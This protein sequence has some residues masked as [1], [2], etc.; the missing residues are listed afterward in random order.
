MD[1]SLQKIELK[2]FKFFK[3]PFTFPV[4]GKHILLYGEN[5]QRFLLV[6]GKVEGILIIPME[7]WKFVCKLR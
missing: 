7:K 5:G 3:E 4:K 2:N 6:F 1:L